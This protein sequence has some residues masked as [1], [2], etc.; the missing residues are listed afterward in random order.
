MSS[1]RTRLAV[2]LTAVGA[3]MSTCGF[4]GTRYLL[5]DN[6]DPRNFS[7]E[8]GGVNTQIV[9]FETIGLF[10]FGLGLILLCL[11]LLRSLEAKRHDVRTRAPV[12]HEE[13][14][15]A[16]VATVTFFKRDELTTDLICCEV[17]IKAPVEKTLFFHEEMEAWDRLLAHLSQLSGFR[18]D[19]YEMVVLPA[20]AENRTVAYRAEG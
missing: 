17:A 20:F 6:Y 1:K 18:P 9:V 3:M 14:P 15:L 4:R 12:E 2:A 7:K 8:P 11:P 19:W 10:C 13:I 5:L 16:D